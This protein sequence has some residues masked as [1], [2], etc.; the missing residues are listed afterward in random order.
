MI[1]ESLFMPET[2]LQGDDF[3]AYIIWN[4]YEEIEVT[5][6]YPPTI[7]I[8]NIYNVPKDGIKVINKIV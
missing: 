7:D 4:K 1:V 2:C 8:K 6:D 3:P 5:V